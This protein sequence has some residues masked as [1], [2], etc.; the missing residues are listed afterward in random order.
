MLGALC[1]LIV[2]LSSNWEHRRKKEMLPTAGLGGG[3]LH[4]GPVL[5]HAGTFCFLLYN[6]WFSTPPF[7]VKDNRQGPQLL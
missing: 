7:P 6:F 3:I 1:T 2:A 4:C 5:P